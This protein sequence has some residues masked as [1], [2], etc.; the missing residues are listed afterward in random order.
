MKIQPSD[1]PSD[2][3]KPVYWVRAEAGELV[4]EAGKALPY[5]TIIG[6]F[7]RL[8]NGAIR[9]RVWPLPE[10]KRLKGYAA[11]AKQAIE[12]SAASMTRVF[13]PPERPLSKAADEK[14]ARKKRAVAKL[15]ASYRGPS[16]NEIRAS[17][18]PY[19]PSAAQLLRDAEKRERIR[20]E[21]LENERQKMARAQAQHAALVER[22]RLED[23]QRAAAIRP[24]P[25]PE[26][27]RA[28]LSCAGTGRRFGGQPC[29][30]CG[31]TGR[32]RLSQ[33]KP[34]EHRVIADWSQQRAAAWSAPATSTPP[35]DSERRQMEAEERDMGR[36]MRRGFK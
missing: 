14:R 26:E 33:L 23:A 13:G 15:Q 6:E 28:C 25:E 34:Y 4:T 16:Y 24:V 17:F 10:G 22:H 35:T 5:G 8:K 21:Q 11:A 31:G 18:P 1:D 19:V 12:A 29:E 36:K 9:V 20:R 2:Q 30:R 32:L 3:G 7:T 27:T